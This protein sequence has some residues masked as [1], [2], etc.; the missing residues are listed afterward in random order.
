MNTLTWLAVVALALGGCGKSEK[1][2]ASGSAAATTTEGAPA[3]PTATKPGLELFTSKVPALPPP[4]D[5]I[6]PGMPGAEA[7]AAAPEVFA[8][9]YGYKVPGYDGVEIKVQLSDK[10]D[11]VFVTMIELKE[12]L[13]A[14]KAELAKKW[15]EPRATKNSIDAA[16]Y[17]WDDAVSGIRAKLQGRAS[18]SVIIF[19]EVTSLDALL[20]TT[21]GQFGFET[22]P[23]LGATKEGVLEAYEARYP[24]P[25]DGDPDS[26]VW[27]LPPHEYGEYGGSVDARI[28][29]GKVSGYSVS[30]SWSWDETAKEKVFKALEML[31][32]GKPKPDGKL[33]LDYPGPPKLKASHDH[34]TQTTIW[35]GDTKK[36]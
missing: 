20:G 18:K 5:K 25:R 27:N 24:H 28:K 15:G 17:Y 16:E 13:E 7:K 35:V 22:T 30:L 1:Q 21:P 14:A 31:F 36:K 23:L 9:K 29:D 4:V 12:P 33:Y 6:K 10:T 11:R 26:I 19:S 2:Q 3:E 8:A 34:K 32:G